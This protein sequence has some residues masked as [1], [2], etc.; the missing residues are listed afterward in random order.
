[1]LS[2]KALI[3]KAGQGGWNISNFNQDAMEVPD[4]QWMIE[5]KHLV[6]WTLAYMQILFSDYAIGKKVRSPSYVGEKPVTEG[7]NAL[8]AAQKMKKAGGFMLVHLFA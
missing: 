2:I 3:M 4:N 8:C 6:S 1:M 7:G 5:S